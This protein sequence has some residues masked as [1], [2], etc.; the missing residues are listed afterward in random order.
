MFART[1]LL[2]ICLVLVG[3][4]IAEALRPAMADRRS[5]VNQ[6]V[7]GT[8]GAAVIA[9]TTPVWAASDVVAAYQKNGGKPAE[10]KPQ[11]RSTAFRGG[12]GMAKAT[13]DGTD[14]NAKESDVAGGLLDKMGLGDVKGAKANS[15]D[16]IA[17]ISSRT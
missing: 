4:N 3:H 11:K 16:R 8:T 10:P 14:L 17:S 5:F 1:L 15:D 12:Q 13:H 6:L 7:A 2:L 9:S